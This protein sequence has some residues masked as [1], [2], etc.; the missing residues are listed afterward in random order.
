M[1]AFLCLVGSFN[2]LVSI[3]ATIQERIKLNTGVG[4]LASAT[5]GA[6]IVMAL[7][8]VF[9]MPNTVPMNLDS[10][11]QEVQLNINPKA[12]A[13]PN[14][15]ANMI[16]GIS[17]FQDSLPSAIIKH[18]DA[19]AVSKKQAVSAFLGPR[20]CQIAPVRKAAIAS[21]NDYTTVLR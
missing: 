12:A 20:A 15:A 7:A 3:T 10:K 1:I 9:I 2:I 21:A 14:F 11:K 6:N 13:M 8:I 18:T 17:A 4:Q 5:K 19:R 16:G